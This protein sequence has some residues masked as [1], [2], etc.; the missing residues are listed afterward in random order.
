[1]YFKLKHK[2]LE[3]TLLF[4]F[5]YLPRV[6]SYSIKNQAQK[7]FSPASKNRQSSIHQVIRGLYAV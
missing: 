1:M 5:R 7:K 3:K 4:Y 2:Y 6:N